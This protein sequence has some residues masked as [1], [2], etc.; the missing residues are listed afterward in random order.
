MKG[1]LFFDI[2][3][4]LNSWT[5][6]VVILNKN[7]K[8]QNQISCLI[9]DHWIILCGLSPIKFFLNCSF[10][11]H[12]MILMWTKIWNSLFSP[13]SLVRP[14]ISYWCHGYCNSW[15]NHALIIETYSFQYGGNSTSAEEVLQIPSSPILVGLCE[16]GH[17]ATKNSLQHSQG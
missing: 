11:A 10:Y 1:I 13:H 9:V 16:E 14:D 3:D 6:L 5:S 2:L 7:L 4:C 12:F 17:P 15:F 8:L